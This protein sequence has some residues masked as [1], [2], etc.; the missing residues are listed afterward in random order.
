MGLRHVGE[1]EVR[2]GIASHA[3]LLTMSNDGPQL[4][5]IRA[6]ELL[7]KMIAGMGLRREQVYIGNIVKCRPPNNRV[8]IPDEVATCSPYL[9]RQLEIIRPEFIC[10]LGATSSKALL[11]SEVSIGKLRKKFHDY[12]GIPVLCTYHPASLLPSRSPENKRLVW[13]DMKMLLQKMG[14]PIPQGKKE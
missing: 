12:R 1:R 11:N 10:C 9:L 5:Q 8:P 2:G 13:E 4:L 3:W 14:R 6:G 7:N